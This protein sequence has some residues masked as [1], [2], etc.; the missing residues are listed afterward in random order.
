MCKIILKTLVIIP[1]AVLV[2]CLIFFVY[3]A[4]STKIFMNENIIYT[5]P[6]RINLNIDARII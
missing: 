1:F 3:R 5:P 2:L 4:E 6:I